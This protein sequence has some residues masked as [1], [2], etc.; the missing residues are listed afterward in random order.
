MNAT[1]DAPILCI[2]EIL[3]DA[4][5]AGLFLGGAV[6]NVGCHLQ[7]LGEPVRFAS[8]VGDDALG[9][10]AKR[11]MRVRG[12]DTSFVQIDGRLPTGFVEIN[13]KADGVPEY[14]IRAPAAWDR[15]E[16]TEDL[17]QC[18]QDF[19]AM[20]FGTLAQRDRVSRATIETLYT[21]SFLKVCDINLRWPFVDQA[22]VQRSLDAADVAKLNADELLLLSR[23]WNLPS[24]NRDASEALA[25]R[26]NLQMVCITKGAGGASLWQQGQWFEHPG[27][28]AVV[29]NTVGSGDAFLAGLLHR[30]LVGDKGG[31]ALAFANRM[32]AWVAAHSGATPLYC[33]NEIFDLKV[34]AA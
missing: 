9:R 30:L 5:P 7:G 13:L 17:A 14:T 22:V 19:R 18:A 21:N 34:N 11:R 20:V 10:E 33:E 25:D 23:W 2:G 15:I 3:Y 29:I 26:F 16:L 27:F 28:S 12:M 4:L 31:E 32:G 1:T 24:H 6:F 8:R